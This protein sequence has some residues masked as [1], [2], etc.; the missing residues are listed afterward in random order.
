MRSCER[1]C[2]QNC[3]SLKE[4]RIDADRCVLCLRCIEACPGESFPCLRRQDGE[5][6]AQGTAPFRGRRGGGPCSHVLEQ[7][8]V[9]SATSSASSLMIGFPYLLR[10]RG[11]T[12]TSRNGAW[13]AWRVR[14]P[15]PPE[16]SV[17]LLRVG[18][19]GFSSLSSTT[20]RLLPVQLQCLAGKHAR[21]AQ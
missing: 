9:S 11:V 14:Q 3:I 21:Q 16:L 6:C 13:P 17:R 5:P 20:K 7:E 4:R 1:S 10:A 19:R 2:P 15:V 8:K 12:E 18:A